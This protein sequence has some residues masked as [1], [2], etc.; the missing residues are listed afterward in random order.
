VCWQLNVVGRV[1]EGLHM[2]RK[3]EAFAALA[4]RKVE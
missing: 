2:M 1:R 3:N 4:V